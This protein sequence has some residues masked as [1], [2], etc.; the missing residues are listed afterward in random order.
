MVIL[1]VGGDANKGGNL[2]VIITRWRGRQQG[3]FLESW[4]D[5]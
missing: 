1:L 4:D 5:N 3:R 2:L